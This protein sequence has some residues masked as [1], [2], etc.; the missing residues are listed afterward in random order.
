[1]IDPSSIIGREL[2]SFSAVP[3]RGQLAFFA[4]V[5]GQTDPTYFDL[6]AARAKGH[7]DLPVPPTFLFSLELRRPNPRGILTELGIDMRSVLHGE[8]EFRYPAM[9]FAGQQLDFTGTYVDYYEKKG[10]A[11][12]FLVR[13]TEVKRD[14]EPIAVLKNVLI[15]RQLELTS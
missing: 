4:Q 5:L 2:S 3:E 10:G 7:P 12:R 11:M 8:Q 6:D 9:A 14:G 1:M 13:Q 15:S